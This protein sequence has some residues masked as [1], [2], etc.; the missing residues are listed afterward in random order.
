MVDARSLHTIMP[1]MLDFSTRAA[2]TSRLFDI[3]GRYITGDSSYTFVRDNGEVVR[4]ALTGLALDKPDHYGWRLIK[5]EDVKRSPLAKQLLP[6]QGVFKKS[7]HR[8]V[9]HVTFDSP[10][11]HAQRRSNLGQSSTVRRIL[12]ESVGKLA[13]ADEAIAIRKDLIDATMVVTDDIATLMDY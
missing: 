5:S 6:L 12:G 13:K 4:T 11:S 9:P 8:T 2:G 1:A 10:E 7:T 3:L